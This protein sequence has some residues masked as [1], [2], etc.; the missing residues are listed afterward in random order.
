MDL[1]P[2][3]DM[4]VDDL[5]AKIGGNKAY[6]RALLA[7]WCDPPGNKTLFKI[8]AECPK[9]KPSMLNPKLKGIE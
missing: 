2:L 8:V 9:I 4:T 6:L 3:M 1:R 7:G 5:H